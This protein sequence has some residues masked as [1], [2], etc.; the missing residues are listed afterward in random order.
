ME[1]KSYNRKVL[2]ST[3]L[4][5]VAVVAFG[6]SAYWLKNDMTLLAGKI[7]KLRNDAAANA[8][9]L[10]VLARL[11][12]GSE[13]IDEYQKQIE[14]ILPIEDKLILLKSWLEQVASGPRVSVASNLEMSGTAQD[15]LPAFSYFTIVAN[16]DY[17]ALILFMREIESR[18]TSYLITLE[19]MDIT[20]QSDKYQ[21]VAKGK[22]YY[23]HA[24]G[25]KL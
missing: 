13:E 4:I 17:S 24:L 25:E 15:G 3:L 10:E 18:S 19:T 6:A 8:N 5:L 22:I 9:S 16:G 21:L 2:W 11:K 12:Q 1:E 23:K 20:R 7:S 14:Q